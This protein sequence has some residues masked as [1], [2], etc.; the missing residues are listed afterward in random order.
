MRKGSTIAVLSLV[1]TAT[2]GPS[3]VE[4]KSYN[5]N[6]YRLRDRAMTSHNVRSTGDSITCLTSEARNLLARIRSKFNNV[7]IVST[8][9]PGAKIA[10]TNYP[11]KHASGQ[12][13]DF[14]VPGRKAEVVQWLIANH[15]NGGTM[16]YNDMDHIHVDV[17]ARFVALNRPSGRT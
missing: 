8:C 10:G 5:G 14:R 12:A 13:I 1:L 3:L 7:Q 16:T 2:T 4:A 11:S 6:G 9:R 15:K 17:G